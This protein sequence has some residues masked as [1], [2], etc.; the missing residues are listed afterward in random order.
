MIPTTRPRRSCTAIFRTSDP[1]GAPSPHD[2]QST[3][4]INTMTKASE[5]VFVLYGWGASACARIQTWAWASTV[6]VSAG[7]EPSA[8]P[9]SRLRVGPGSIPGRTPPPP[10]HSPA[11]GPSLRVPPVL[12]PEQTQ[13]WVP[14]S[15]TVT[16]VTT[17]SGRAAAAAAAAGGRGVG[18]SGGSE[19]PTHTIPPSK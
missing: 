18:G 3:P 9:G 8:G 2:S 5:S 12:S 10:P 6:T 1:S 13:H 14:L 4:T 19:A 7:R 17:C 15:G 11:T 16:V